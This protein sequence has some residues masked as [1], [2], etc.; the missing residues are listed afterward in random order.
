MADIDYAQLF[1]DKFKI[2]DELA[3]SVPFDIYSSK[4]RAQF[5]V[6]KYLGTNFE[7]PK[8]AIFLKARKMGVSSVVLAAYTLDFIYRPNSV[9]VVIAHENSSTELLLDKVR[10]YLQSYAE[11]MGMD[12]F[13]L[14]NDNNKN[15]KNAANGAEFRIGTAGQKGLLRS[16]TIQNILFSEV[17]FYDLPELKA[18]QIISGAI[19]AVPPN[20]PKTR[21]IFETTANGFNHFYNRWEKAM[22]GDS[23]YKPIF[24][25]ADLFYTKDDLE[26]IRRDQGNDEMFKQEY[27]MSPEEAFRTSGEKFFDK[28]VLDYMMQQVVKPPI[29]SGKLSPTGAWFNLNDH[30]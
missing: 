18:N 10:Y 16:Q 13:P 14:E 11:T 21:I 25:S 7:E 20:T 15:L 17:A 12:H 6:A 4:R 3:Q 26:A 1:K 24:L 9:S 5:E 29:R 2:A 28:K 19:A 30:V 22:R 8:R 23:A 27:P